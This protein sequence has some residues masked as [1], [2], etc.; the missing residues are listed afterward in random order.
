MR[1]VRL[2]D[3]DNVLFVLKSFIAIRCVGDPLHGGDH[4]LEQNDEMGGPFSSGDPAYK[5][6]YSTSNEPLST[7]PLDN[8]RGAFRIIDSQLHPCFYK[9]GQYKT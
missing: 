5:D 7:T 4:I 8:L 1:T 2:F 9:Q 3:A 6:L